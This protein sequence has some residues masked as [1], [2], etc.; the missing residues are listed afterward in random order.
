MTVFF[1]VSQ[2]AGRLGVGAGVTFSIDL[3]HELPPRQ[4]PPKN[5]K[6]GL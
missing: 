5:R 1:L 2:E 3:T 4:H 6:T